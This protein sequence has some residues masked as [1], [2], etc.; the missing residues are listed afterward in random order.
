MSLDPL[1]LDQ[2]LAQ[3]NV[4]RQN[5]F[6][7]AITL[8]AKNGSVIWGMQ[9]EWY[10]W[11]DEQ[12]PRELRVPRLVYPQFVDLWISIHQPYAIIHELDDIF[13]FLVGGGNALVE[14]RLF[15]AIFGAR[16]KPKVSIPHGPF[17]F[18]GKSMFD[19]SAFKR[20]PN[21]KLRM[22]VFTRDNR[23]CRICGRRPDDNVDVQLHVHHIRPWAR[24]GVTD[25]QNLITLCHTC[26]AG[27]DPHE[28][29][30]LFGYVE[31][32][33]LRPDI[34]RELEEFTAGVA[35]YRRI[36]FLG[37]SSGEGF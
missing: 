28:D 23:R 33:S 5:T 20:A 6:Y 27:L 13:L 21:P 14:E 12:P 29:I 17:G 3:L 4:S 35:E 30:S 18:S 25:Q 34:Q 26:H 7:Y 36:G 8:L 15:K 37:E 11:T 10:G 24:G 19:A 2:R 22:K 9:T 1:T 16:L 32:S 31:P